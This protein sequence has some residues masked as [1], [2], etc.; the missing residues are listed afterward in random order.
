MAPHALSL[1]AVGPVSAELAPVQACSAVVGTC[2]AFLEHAVGL[3]RPVRATDAL[4]TSHSSRKHLGAVAVVASVGFVTSMLYWRLRGYRRWM[5]FEFGDVEITKMTSAASKKLL[6]RDEYTSLIPEVIQDLEEAGDSFNADAVA[7]DVE[8]DQ[9]AK[10][11]A[12]VGAPP[13]RR[14]LKEHPSA[15]TFERRRC[16]ILQLNIGLYCNQACTHCHVESSPLRKEMMSMEVVEQCLT[17]LRE[18][19]SVKVLDITGGAPE[20]NQG[21]R[22]L[23]EGAAQIRESGVR[24]DL[25]IIDRC[26]LTVLFEPGQ[27][28]LADFLAEH[29]VEIVASLPS[30]DESQTD[31]QRGRKVFQRSVEGLKLLNSFGYGKEGSGLHLELVFNPPGAFLPPRQDKL[32]LK[33]KQELRAEHGIEF[34]NLIAICNMP[35]KRFFDYLRKNDMLE[36]YMDLLVR[37]FNPDTV[38][39]LMCSET[40]SVGWDGRVYDCDFNQQLEL[41]LG[42]GKKGGG[43]T[44]FDLSSLQEEQLLKLPIRTAAH[45]FGCTAAQG[46]G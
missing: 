30:Y 1:D 42:Q 9:R 37:N 20:L 13:F 43:L 17:L 39:G 19:P 28:K 36:G 12:A 14:F 35:V 3:L 11:L 44:V 40:I 2:S 10:A 5:D 34:N 22:R 6:K 26:N 21:F 33:F 24:P 32:E 23:V 46:S 45:C 16:K 4:G 8:V 38:S 7:P 15:P 41:T 18:S 27:E 29:K 25:R 31:K